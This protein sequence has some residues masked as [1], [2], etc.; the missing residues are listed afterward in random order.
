MR[1]KPTSRGRASASG[2]VV[3][4]AAS[5]GGD[6]RNVFRAGGDRAAVDCRA[7][8]AQARSLRTGAARRAL[9]RDQLDA[10]IDAI[11]ATGYGLTLGIQ[12]RIDE[13]AAA[14]RSRVRAGNVYVNRNMIGAVVGVQ[15]FGGH[16]LSGTGPKAGGPLYVRR[17]TRGGARA[18]LPEAQ[19]LPGPTGETNTLEFHPR[20]VVACI[21]D[22]AESPARA[23]PRR[24][25]PAT[26]AVAA[27]PAHARRARPARW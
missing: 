1:S 8:R 25:A 19:S 21:A 11:N 13:T 17:L 20:G 7:R 12:T 24:A 4:A 2:A 26:L 18:A 22:D 5:R 10:L 27:Q 23:D 14:I 3:A 16:G 6:A 15:P 9:A